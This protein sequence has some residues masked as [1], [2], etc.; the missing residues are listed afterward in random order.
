MAKTEKEIQDEKL[1]VLKDKPV[2]DDVRRSIEEK[3]KYVN[4]PICK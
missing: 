4:K 2:S 1:K 3:Q